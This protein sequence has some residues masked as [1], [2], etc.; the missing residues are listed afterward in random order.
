MFTKFLNH[1][2]STLSPLLKGLNHPHLQVIKEAFQDLVLP[3]SLASLVHV[4]MRFEGFLSG[5]VWIALNFI[6][7]QALPFWMV[8]SVSYR[9]LQAST[10]PIFVYLF[11]LLAGLW[12]IF[13]LN[14]LNALSFPYALLYALSGFYMIRFLHRFFFRYFKNLP[15][16][17]QTHLIPLGVS[18]LWWMILYG[19]MR[20]V[21]PTYPWFELMYQIIA[22]LN[23]WPFLILINSLIVLFWY[24]GFHGTNLV[25]FV[26]LPLGMVGLLINLQATYPSVVIAGYTHIIF[27]NWTAYY[28][29][30]ILSLSLAKSKKLKQLGRISW[31]SSL[32]NINEHLIFGL[33]QVRNKPLLPYLLITTSSN[34]ILFA[35]ALQQQW[36]DPI[37]YMSPFIVILPLQVLW[38]SFSFKTLGFW[39]VLL[40]LNCL[41][42]S[43]PFH[44]MDREARVQEVKFKA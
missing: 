16:F 22:F 14:L 6:S 28:A 1:F 5:D 13:D 42:L 4:L 43:V 25:A 10:L 2:E 33:P 37:Q 12:A 9:L 15:A 41:I 31:K 20:F 29:L 39:F 44:Q 19:V 3:L 7:L 17:L 27:G 36:I 11:T 35:F 23:Q 21:S 32:F 26:L 30:V 18:L 38:A 8:V 40:L 24:F 34:L